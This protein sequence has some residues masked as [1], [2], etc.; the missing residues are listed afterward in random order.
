MEQNQGVEKRKKYRR[1][2]GLYRRGRGPTANWWGNVKDRKGIWHLTN[3][4]TFYKEEALQI[5]AEMRRKAKEGKDWK[6]TGIGTKTLFSE[7]IPKAL[8]VIGAAVKPRTK[9]DYERIANYFVKLVGDHYV[10]DMTTKELIQF[11]EIRRQ[12]KKKG[13]TIR[14]DLFGLSAIFQVAVH[15]EYGLLTTNPVRALEK[16]PRADAPVPKALTARGLEKLLGAAKS[17]DDL[18]SQIAIR[19]LVNTGIRSGEAHGLEWKDIDFEDRLLR[20]K[21]GK[22][23]AGRE[24]P[25]NQHAFDLLKFMEKHWIHAVE[26]KGQTVYPR[27]STMGP[28]VFIREDGRSYLEKKWKPG[29]YYSSSPCFL[30]G[31]FRRTA[32]EANVEA[33]IHATRHTFATNL[34]SVGVDLLT[35]K[36]LMGHSTRGDVTARYAQVKMEKLREAVLAIEQFTPKWDISSVALTRPEGV[37][38]NLLPV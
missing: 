2:G 23:Y 17:R 6:N 5:L 31:M 22:N 38:A 16:K 28:W 24:I 25:L 13:Q 20:L 12:E 14:N 21:P 37:K 36:K 34:A 15:P 32:E 3:T 26:H 33:S 7:F 18:V 9:K 1:R 29:E 27:S 11:I 4:R 19:L 30:N 8:Q 10:E 35:I